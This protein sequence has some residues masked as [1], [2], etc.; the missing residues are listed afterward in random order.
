[1]YLQNGSCCGIVGGTGT[2]HP[3]KIGKIAK[4]LI[5]VQIK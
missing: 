1:M 5:L 4:K 2:N 3:V